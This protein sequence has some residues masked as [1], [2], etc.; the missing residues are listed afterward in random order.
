M[1][2]SLKAIAM[3]LIAAAIVGGLAFLTDRYFEAFWPTMVV[4]LVPTVIAFLITMVGLADP[5][6]TMAAGFAVS[7]LVWGGIFFTLGYWM[8][9][10]NT[11][12]PL[13]FGIGF[14]A[15]ACG[16]FFIMER[17]YAALEKELGIENRCP[18]C[19]RKLKKPEQRYMG[20]SQTVGSGGQG[21]STAHWDSVFVCKCGWEGTRA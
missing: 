8:W 14:A 17:S 13:W 18:Q 7:L 12:S 11:L 10:R 4:I 20:S 1:N 6:K 5:L 19:N 9:E 3:G 16:T 2:E 15:A 21:Y